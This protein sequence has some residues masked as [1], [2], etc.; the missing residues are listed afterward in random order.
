MDTT[1]EHTLKKI[2]VDIL[3]LHPDTV[4]A[5]TMSNTKIWDSFTHIS[6]VMEIEQNCIEGQIGAEKITELTSFKKCL[7]FVSNHTGP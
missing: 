5:A 3:K 7:E 1:T 2:F 4:V 6:L